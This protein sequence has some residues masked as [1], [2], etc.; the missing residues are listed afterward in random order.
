MKRAL[1]LLACWRLQALV[2]LTVLTTFPAGT[3]AQVS[4][5]EVKQAIRRGM[6]YLE[7]QASGLSG[8]LRDL[9]AYAYL[10]AGGS[11]RTPFVRNAVREVLRKVRDGEYKPVQ[12]HI[13]EA[14]VDSMLLEEYDK[15]KYKPQM[16]AIAR[17]L[18]SMQGDGGYWE[19]P[20]R[21]V[22]GDTSI[23]QY[24]AL[25][26]WS[27]A[28]CGIHIPLRVWEGLARWL[29]RTQLD[30]GAFAYW[31]VGSEK[32][33]PRREPRHS[34]TAAGVGALL[35]ARLYIAGGEE[36]T[37]QRKRKKKQG[38]LGVLEA[39]EEEQPEEE[40]QPVDVLAESEDYVPQLKP[41]QL[42]PAITR[43]LAWLGANFDLKNP[44]GEPIYYMYAMER[45]GALAH[46]THF[47][48]HDWYAEG[49]A[50]LLKTQKE[51]GSWHTGWH[52][53]IGPVADT[54]FA[55]LFLSKSTAKHVRQIVPQAFGGGLLSGARGLPD[56]LSQAQLRDGAIVGKT[57]ST[58][59]DKLL[60]DLANPDNYDVSEAQQQLVQQVQLG[61]R[62]E[63][64]GQKE[65]LVE[66]AKDPR[67]EV[68][69]TAMWALGR[70]EDVRLA[71]ILIEGLKDPDFAVA[72][73][74]YNALCTLS[75][76]PQGLG[77]PPP[78]WQD[79]QPPDPAAV[80]KWRQEAVEAW[81]KWYLEVRPYDERDD[82]LGL[83]LP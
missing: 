46:T 29:M 59:L 69:R 17:Y 66:L 56:D 27:A 33:R 82:P 9:A 13:Y 43:G 57:V 42:D 35:I 50:H 65:L 51:D 41:K 78:E 38:I 58:P 21:H 55:L 19:Y 47:G 34:T 8:P 54:A 32:E 4:S 81:T 5:G 76:R 31:P 67:V 18:V 75:R 39:A 62:E 20:D 74:A 48:S 25:G 44:V 28:R 26:L 23:T 60:A 15:E 11:K 22:G 14:G 2:A 72:V 64:T 40:K 73:E 53:S 10:V 36:W 45:V 68:R 49:A 71:R 77:P 6:S 79:D 80:E 83:K 37:G 70:C 52:Q 16:E 30:G 24:A 63:L 1:A 12:H 7:Q 61:N 3:V